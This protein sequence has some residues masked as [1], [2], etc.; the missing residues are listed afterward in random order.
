[1]EIVQHLYDRILAHIWDRQQCR[2]SRL[3]PPDHPIV[4]LYATLLA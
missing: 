3:Q 2:L 1:M 4:R